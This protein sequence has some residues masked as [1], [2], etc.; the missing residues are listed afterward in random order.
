[1][2]GCHYLSV[3]PGLDRFP[4]F[5]LSKTKS[6]DYLLASA[7]TCGNGA[8]L[9]RWRLTQSIAAFKLINCYKYNALDHLV[10][11]YKNYTAQLNQEHVKKVECKSQN[12]SSKISVIKITHYV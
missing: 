6:T 5:C 8:E 2:Y 1:M 10:L 7:S 12:L 3:T 11:G 9:Q 4:D